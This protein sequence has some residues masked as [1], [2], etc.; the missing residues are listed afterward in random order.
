MGE[1]VEV[2]GP[3][4]TIN[5]PGVR[6][7]EQVRIGELGLIG[8]VIHLR[9]ENALVQVYESTESLRPGEQVEGLGHPLSV[10][11]GPGLLGQIFDGV[12]R[13]LNKIMQMSGE[14]ISRGLQVDALDRSKKWHFV[15]DEKLVVGYKLSGG[16]IIGTVQETE[17][18]KSVV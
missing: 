15:P 9:E 2:N 1:V 8:E 16:E 11:L 5:Q 14:N 6:N 10:E 13:P 3:I 17:D 4:V 7:G 18:R 12:Q